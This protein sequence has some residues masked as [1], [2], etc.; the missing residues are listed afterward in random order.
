[1]LSAKTKFKKCKSC[2]QSI[3]G[4]NEQLLKHMQSNSICRKSIIHCLG[5]GKQCVSTIHL[6]NHQSQ[7]RKKD[8]NT[9]CIQTLEKLDHVNSLSISSPKF[10][11]N[12]QSSPSH[13]KETQFFID[14]P[15]L[16]SNINLNNIDLHDCDDE[17]VTTY[18]ENLFCQEVQTHLNES[19]KTYLQ[20][21]ISCLNNVTKPLFKN[22]KR[23]INSISTSNSKMKHSRPS[24]KYQSCT[25]D[26]NTFV[27]DSKN[28]R[29]HSKEV[30]D[31]DSTYNLLKLCE[32]MNDSDVAPSE[33]D[34]I[35]NNETNSLS[36][37]TTSGTSTVYGHLSVNSD[38]IDSITVDL[39]HDVN[40]LLS[41]NSMYIHDRILFN[42]QHRKETMFSFIDKAL[43]DLY[44]LHK[45]TR[46]PIGLFDESVQWMVKHNYHF[47]NSSFGTSAKIPSRKTFMKD[48][49]NKVYSKEY[50]KY[51]KPKIKMIPVDDEHCIQV[52][53][54]DFREVLVDLLSNEDLMNS[55]VLQFYDSN[56]PTLIHPRDC[57]V[58]E[59]ITSDVFFQAHE[60]LCRKKNDVLFP[61]VMYS[62]EI[63]FDRLS[64]LKL[65]PLSVTFGRFPILLRNQSQAWR[66]FG[67]VE[68]I[69]QNQ[70]NLELD[71]K[72]KM[73][74]YHKCLKSIFK[75]L[76]DLQNEG[77]I[78]YDL[79]LKNGQVMRVNL[80]VYVQFIIGD[81]KGHDHLC[82]RMGSYH[83]SMKQMV[84]DCCVTPKDCDNLNHICKF[85]KIK[86]VLMFTKDEQYKDISF[87]NVD[88]ALYDLEFGDN[89]H[90]IF[91]ACV[92]EPLHMLE[93]QLIELITESFVDSLCASSQKML[94]QSIINIVGQV[95]TQSI[96]KDFNPI[97]AFREGLTQIKCLTG[98]ER[99]GKLFIIFLTLLNS[100][101]SQFIATKPPKNGHNS[102]KI[103]GINRITKWFELIEDTLILMQWLK[104]PEH[105]R[106]DLYNPKW[107]QDIISKNK[108]KDED[109]LMCV[110]S[111]AQ[112]KILAYLKKYKLLIDRNANGLKIPKFHLMLHLVRNI[113]RHG[114]IPNYDGSRP[115]SIA[116]DLAK[117]PGLRTQKQQKSIT[118]Q[119]AIRYHEDQTILEAERLFNYHSNDNS[120]IAD[121]YWTMNNEDIYCSEKNKII[122]QGSNY[123]LSVH[124]S[125]D[126]E[127]YLNIR[128]TIEHNGTGLRTRVDDELL[129]SVTNWLWVDPLGGT[130]SLKSSPKFYCE[131]NKDGEIYRCHPCYRSEV[132]K[133]DWVLVDWGEPYSHPIPARLHLL[134][135]TSGCEV[136]SEE[137]Y[138]EQH[139]ISGYDTS[140]VV[141]LTKED[142]DIHQRASNYLINNSLWAVVHSADNNGIIDSK[143][144]PSKYHLKSKIA[145]RV[146]MEIDR[147]R[148][149]P[150]TD[151]VGKTLGMFNH[152]KFKK[153]KTPYDN[154]A[155]IVDPQ[156]SWEKH[157][158]I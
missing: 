75:S 48:M 93:M 120:D 135:D 74:I 108:F 61:L 18:N 57:N 46:A 110:G 7:Q 139:K 100:N 82:G 128:A 88:N 25:K 117:S 20:N 103:F 157:F 49:Y 60:R 84:R 28:I 5:C 131:M 78:P 17:N 90:G 89:I 30:I 106:K 105:N 21:S 63:N 10:E 16:S 41:P 53:M 37:N 137:M 70:T 152:L 96:K 101:C 26:D 43:I 4:N 155:F 23:L 99:H 126:D 11:I 68:S 2:H 1:M 52:T 142:N 116:K 73:K 15:N 158:L 27:Q 24:K 55:N 83:L 144:Y 92:G 97:N 140:N 8:G 32:N 129:M 138:K 71:A 151:I 29:N 95:E 19:T 14:Q 51:V 6:Q 36:S 42:Q 3:R 50:T 40:S 80:I 109:D 31:S 91:G 65:D 54:F 125:N 143:N 39:D 9:F 81:T 35:D 72:I 113:C 85:R 98:K 112:Q 64:K 114:S 13:S 133:F 56:N 121:S 33:L 136:I 59:I 123:Y 115:E 145:S 122:L 148:I 141:T 127:S 94:Q 66:Y 38:T 58:G 118:F 87:H 150:I 124:I 111:S 119:T 156:K 130:I 149:I 69:K 34:T 67:F 107:F 45:R 104:K 77:G 79:K 134:F 153:K 146:T 86:D 76:K 47:D 154:T 62:D 132:A 44:L 147:Y 12:K 102:G 22:P